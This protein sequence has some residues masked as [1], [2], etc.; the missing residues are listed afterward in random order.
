MDINIINFTVILTGLVLD[1]KKKKPVSS[2]STKP[3]LIRLL[4][5]A[6]CYDS[7]L[8]KR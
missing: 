2:C 8:D 1:K 6:T 3:G 4:F 5:F 7:W